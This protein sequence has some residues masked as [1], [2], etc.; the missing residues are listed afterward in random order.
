MSVTCLMKILWQSSSDG[1]HDF[2]FLKTRTHLLL[3]RKS[4]F[5]SFRF[6]K[7]EFGT[8]ETEIVMFESC[9][10]FIDTRILFLVSFFFC[11][12]EAEIRESSI[13]I[14]LFGN[15]SGFRLSGFFFFV[16]RLDWFR[17]VFRI[18]KIEKF[19]RRCC[20]GRNFLDVYKI[21]TKFRFRY[22]CKKNI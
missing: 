15:E 14:R 8:F 21:T 22:L 3:G 5:R 16:S 20:G 9:L 12:L 7:P 4:Q 6:N 1:F 10:Q 18:I 17:F 11:F 13:G 19:W 2:G